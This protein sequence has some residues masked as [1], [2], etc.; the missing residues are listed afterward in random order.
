MLL[1]SS[2][3][4]AA[5]P[6]AGEPADPAEA[7]A[8][9]SEKGQLLRIH[10]KLREARTQF[11]ACVKD[12]CPAVVRKDCGQFLV[13]VEAATPTVVLAVRDEKGDLTDV[14]VTAN[15]QVIADR[16]EGKSIAM[17]PGVY[18]LR[19]EAKGHVSATQKVVVREGERNRVIG[20]T[21][22]TE[23]L[24]ADAPKPP[25]AA[26]VFA[27]VAVVGASAFGVLG[28][29]ARSQYRDLKDTCAPRCDEDDIDRA[30]RTAAFA[31][32]ALVLGVASAG[33][34]TWLFVDHAKRAEVRAVARGSWLG[35]EAQF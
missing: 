35:I 4:L 31:D 29:S 25:V 14:R 28:L 7:C 22:A 1:V 15:G 21:L 24:V 12:A 11:L 8:D 30:K 34:A 32:V 2:R 9:A 23:Q 10:G 6:P 26:W 27:G 17:D 18:E 13:D 20:V 5:P 16:L 3:A 19:F 33:V